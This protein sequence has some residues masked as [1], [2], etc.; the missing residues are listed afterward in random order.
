MRGLHCHSSPYSTGEGSTAKNSVLSKESVATKARHQ[1]AAKLVQTGFLEP[2]KFLFNSFCPKNDFLVG[3][4][5]APEVVIF[6]FF[7][8]HFHL[9][10]AEF[11]FSGFPS[12]PLGQLFASFRASFLLFGLFLLFG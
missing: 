1:A 7:G 3:K 10:L 4:K 2:H 6:R 11:C 9:F 8:Q 5:T 12:V